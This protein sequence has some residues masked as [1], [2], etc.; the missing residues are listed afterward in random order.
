MTESE[1]PSTIS[2]LTIAL[3]AVTL[4]AT[5][6]NG[7]A[8]EEPAPAFGSLYVKSR[9][10]NTSV[11]VDGEDA[12]SDG[13][14]L[15]SIPVGRH[16]VRVS[17]PGCND[18]DTIVTIEASATTRLDVTLDCAPAQTESE[19]SKP[20]DPVADLT[21]RIEAAIAAAQF[22]SARALADRLSALDAD[23]GALFAARV[24]SART[25]RVSHVVEEVRTAW[26]AGE[27]ERGGTRPST[28]CGRLIPRMRLSSGT[29]GRCWGALLHTPRRAHG[30]GVGRSHRRGHRDLRG[31]GRNGSPVA[32]RHRA[33]NRNDRDRWRGRQM[34]GPLGRPTRHRIGARECLRM[35]SC[36]R[37]TRHNACGTRRCCLVRSRLGREGRFRLV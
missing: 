7:C 31:A 23:A 12:G 5:L 25:E 10:E 16:T 8:R 30:Q 24:S 1:R 18:L 27:A 22:D 14:V 34:R 32:R 21:G 33:A 28:S 3:T 36:D 13:V 37:A 17:L 6:L 20:V 15:D 26:R 29:P 35:G 9:P 19:Q 11:L 4:A 2:A